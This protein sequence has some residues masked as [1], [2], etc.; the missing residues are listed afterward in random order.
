MQR[1]LMVFFS[2]TQKLP[3]IGKLQKKKRVGTKSQF[4]KGESSVLFFSSAPTKLLC[5]EDD[6]ET[7]FCCILYEVGFSI[8]NNHWV[9]L[10][11]GTGLFHNNGKEYP[12]ILACE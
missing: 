4:L 9:I 10:F 12:I 5:S 3:T 1:A 11:L 7:A 2:F 8:C 6:S